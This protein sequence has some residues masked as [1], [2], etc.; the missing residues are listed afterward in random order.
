[1][2]TEAVA[3]DGARDGA[4]G[5][6]A[7][8][9]ADVGTE[10]ERPAVDPTAWI[11]WLKV[12]AIAAV[13]SIHTAGFTAIIDGARHKR[14]GQLAILIDIG[15]TFSVPIFVMVSGALLLDPARFTSTSAFLRRRAVRLLPAV[16]FWHLFYWA[17]R[18]WYMHQH[19]S[20]DDALKW[21]LTG[22]LFTAL[23][24]FWIVLGLTI[25][26]PVLIPWIATASRAWLLGAG[27][28]AAAMPALTIATYKM[29]GTPVVWVETPWTW[30][31]FYLGFFLLG[32]GL[33]GIVLRGAWLVLA[34]LAVV[35]I[36]LSLAWQWHNPGTPVILTRLNPVSYYGLGVHV[37]ALLI[38]VVV[39]SVVRTGGL[40]EGLARGATAR[41]ARTLA[42]ATLGVFALHQ[43][44]MVVSWRIPW[45]DGRGAAI[46]A[47]QLIV[48]IG[49]VLV[50][51]Y[52]IV[53]ALRRVP[54]VRRVL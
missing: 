33:R 39:Q 53:L 6:V 7:T 12:V 27:A 46:S 13:V 35:V 34:A 36:G 29:R 44:V 42:D 5:A 17:F 50:V 38:F 4:G 41:W 15:A 18:V 45:F 25:V 21:T 28:L 22:N 49:V 19:V 8:T 47:E 54:Y 1:M 3:D 43:A 32:W 16:V 23:Y 2:T 10:P 48:R 26:A 14:Q 31:V 51:T 24:Y 52:V 9:R 37:Y 30:W 11:S 40:L 20:P